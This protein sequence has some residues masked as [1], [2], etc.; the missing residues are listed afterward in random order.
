MLITGLAFGI[1]LSALLAIRAAYSPAR[2]WF[3]LFKP[4]TTI[5]ILLAALL[6]PAFGSSPCA[7][8]IAVGLG[9]SLAGDIFL[10][11]SDKYFIWGL[12]SFLAA[13][14]CYIPAF[15]SR[16]GFRE[17]P[18]ISL[19]FIAIGLVLTSQIAFR[20]RRLRW[21]VIV[22]GLVLVAMAW[23]A[24]AAW[25]VLG[26]LPALLALAGALLFVVSDTLLAINRFIR[27]FRF[28]QVGVLGTYYAGQALIAASLWPIS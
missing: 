26:S 18:W 12:V 9:F 1:I 25:A 27:R 23:R 3:F 16:A 10:M 7:V 19:P 13:H 17:P 11:L 4:L 21:P 28:A 20:A 14:L 6:T 5:L 2:H 24:C 22:Y 8:L 15:I